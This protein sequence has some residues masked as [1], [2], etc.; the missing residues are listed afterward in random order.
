MGFQSGD[1]FV[2]FKGQ[3]YGLRLTIGALAEIQS[4]LSL[5]GPAELAQGLRKLSPDQT[6]LMTQALLRAFGPDV[7]T[8]LTA[9]DVVNF[10]PEICQIFEEAF[11]EKTK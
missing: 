5:S 1:K 11:R 8:T 10:L 4:V 9:N 7:P 3:K 6:L 2:M